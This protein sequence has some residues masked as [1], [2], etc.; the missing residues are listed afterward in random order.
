MVSEQP[1][2]NRW[3][4]EAAPMSPGFLGTELAALLRMLIAE[5]VWAVVESTPVLLESLFILLVQTVA[6]MVLHVWRRQY[7]G[8]WH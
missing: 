6:P 1:L 8:A 5:V 7:A 3:T 4:G 2:L